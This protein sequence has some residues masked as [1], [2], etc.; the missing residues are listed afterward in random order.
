MAASIAGK[1]SRPA[2]NH[3]K[4]PDGTWAS[5]VQQL[6]RPSAH[7]Q[8]GRNFF[9]LFPLSGIYTHVRHLVKLVTAVPFCFTIL[10]AQA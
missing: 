6:M 2:L 1:I 3:L 7:L 9:K 8:S 5:I 4:L 10:S